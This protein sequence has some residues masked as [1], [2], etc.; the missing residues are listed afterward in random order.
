MNR[1]YIDI[2]WLLT[3]EGEPYLKKDDEKPPGEFQLPASNMIEMQHMELVRK[4]SDKVRA[5]NAD[6]AL[7][8]IENMDRDTFL[9]VVGYIKGVASKLKMTADQQTYAGSDRRVGER[10]E[11]EAA[12]Q[13]S[14][15]P[16][17]RC[18]KDRRKVANSVR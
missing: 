4:F 12:D 15:E 1:L 14:K 18:G 3:G 10:R 7:L 8:Q 6:F 9:E 16:D 2:D 17:R 5:K 11:E 13:F